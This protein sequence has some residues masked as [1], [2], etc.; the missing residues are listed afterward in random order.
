MSNSQTID[1]LTLEVV[2]TYVILI[3]VIC[4]FYMQSDIC[5]QLSEHKRVGSR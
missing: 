2:P 5:K 4:C 1:G 3:V